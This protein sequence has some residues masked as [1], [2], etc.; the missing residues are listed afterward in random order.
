MQYYLFVEFERSVKEFSQLNDVYKY[1]LDN[2]I[3]QGS[4]I[5]VKGSQVL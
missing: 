4:Y 5:I 3:K 2:G 1:L